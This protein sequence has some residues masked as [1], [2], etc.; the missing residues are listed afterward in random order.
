MFSLHTF[1]IVVTII[2]FINF[3]KGDSIKFS[4][5]GTY[6]PAMIVLTVYGVATAA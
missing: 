6:L 3:Y 1:E 5:S 4:T 2:I